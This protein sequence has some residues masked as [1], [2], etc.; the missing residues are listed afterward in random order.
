MEDTGCGMSAE[1]QIHLF[2][3]F[4]RGND[5]SDSPGLGLSICQ[6]YIKALGGD[7]RVQ[8]KKDRGTSV[9]FSIKKN[10]IPKE[11]LIL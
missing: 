8:S 3:R 4:Y 10:D 6:A 5:F 11:E 7:I 2:E 1:Q 9:F